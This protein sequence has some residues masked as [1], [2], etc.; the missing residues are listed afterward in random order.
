M[1]RLERQVSKI[2]VDWDSPAYSVEHV[3][4]QSPGAGWDSWTDRDYKNFVYRLVNMALLE[5]G[6]NREIAHQPFAVKRLRLSQ[7]GLALTSSIAAENEDWSRERIAR[8]QQSVAKLATTCGGS[9]SW[10]GDL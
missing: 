9:L 2:D 5:T 6:F 8:R 10:T 1:A 3:L 7:S 4:P